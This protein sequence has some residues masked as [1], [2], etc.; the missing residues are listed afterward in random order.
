MKV[1]KEMHFEAAHM[2]TGHTGRCSNLHGHSY[3]VQVTVCGNVDSDIDMVTDF[4]CL[5]DAMHSVIDPMDHAFIYDV[6]ACYEDLEFSI[7][8]L[9]FANGKRV[10]G[11]SGRPT[12]ENMAT[13]IATGVQSILTSVQVCN[14]RVWETSTSFAEWRA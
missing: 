5:K 6:D 2:L 11:I 8:N 7:A 4:S 10:V 1:T 3:K 9:L 12:A 14:V 13:L